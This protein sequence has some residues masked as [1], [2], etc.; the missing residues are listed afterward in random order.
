MYIEIETWIT[1][2]GIYNNMKYVLHIWKSLLDGSN[3]SKRPI[4]MNC[5]VRNKY[6]SSD[7][8]IDGVAC[9]Y[10]V[11]IKE[12]SFH[13]FYEVYAQIEKTIL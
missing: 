9:W 5:L 13:H 8:Y 7:V 12:K 10:I 6:F 4:R 1:I 2:A 11:T 3:E